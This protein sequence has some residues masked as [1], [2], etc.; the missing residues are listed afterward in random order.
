MGRIGLLLSMIRGRG[1]RRG[2]ERGVEIIGDEVGSGVVN[3]QREC[4]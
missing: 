2:K 4:E 1:G 3:E